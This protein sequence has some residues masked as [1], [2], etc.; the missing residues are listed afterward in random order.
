[1]ESDCRD[2]SDEIGCRKF[3]I[4]IYLLEYSIAFI[5]KKIFFLKCQH[6]TSVWVF[7]IWD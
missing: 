6:L 1:M 7:Q 5:L 4:F 3:E 2:A